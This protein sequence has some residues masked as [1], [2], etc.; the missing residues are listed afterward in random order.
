V[1]IFVRDT[2]PGLSPEA[3]LRAFEPFFSTKKQGLGMGLAIVRT[4][5]EGHHG[6]VQVENQK[7]GGAIF[8]VQL[9]TAAADSLRARARARDLNAPDG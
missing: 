6:S 1:E 3:Q 8:R 4:I 5:V 7:G 9:P 2:G